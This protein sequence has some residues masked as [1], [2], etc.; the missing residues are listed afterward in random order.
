VQ[1]DCH[2]PVPAGCRSWAGRRSRLF[3]AGSA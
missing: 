2:A 1:P 3:L